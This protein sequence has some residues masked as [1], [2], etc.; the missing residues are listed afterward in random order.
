MKKYNSLKNLY[1]MQNS[2]QIPAFLYNNIWLFLED[3][4]GFFSPLYICPAEYF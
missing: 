4:S 1:L 2:W 3:D